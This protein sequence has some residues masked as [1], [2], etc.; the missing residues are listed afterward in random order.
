M[1]RELGK[2][3]N[4][5]LGDF[6]IFDKKDSVE[7]KYYSKLAIK[8]T[9]IYLFFGLAWIIISDTLV[10]ALVT[11]RFLLMNISII[12][13]WLYV[14]I[15]GALI[16]FLVSSAMKKI[17]KTVFALHNEVA[18]QKKREAEILFLSY[19]DLLTGLHNRRYFEEEIKK[20][21]NERNLPVTAILWDVNG[22]KIVND[23]FGHFAGDELL[24]RFADELS[25]VFKTDSI[26]ARWGGDEFAV[27]LPNISANE[28]GDKCKEV[29][30]SIESHNQKSLPASISWGMATKI[31]CED[32]IVNTL[33]HAEDMLY[34]N[35]L[36]Q[37][38]SSRHNI[39]ESIKK[40][41]YEKDIETEEHAERLKDLSEKLGKLVGI[42]KSEEKEL[43]IYASLH[44]IGKI[45]ISDSIL[46]KKGKLNP[47]E[48]EKMKKHTEVGYR[49]VKSVPEL[50]G[51]AEYILTHHERW[52]GGGYP[53]GISGTDIP[54]LS[55]I[56]SIVDAFDAMTNN[57]PYK[58]A[59]SIEEAIVEIKE[60]AGKQFDP[61]MAMLFIDEVLNKK[62]EAKDDL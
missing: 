3:I 45:A 37:I 19:H 52:D 48:W 40:T 18:E 17:S 15:T 41:L 20:Y 25:S 49:I 4:E 2:Y 62:M 56:V 21:E 42:S 9:G 12:K 31:L 13:G 29:I 54:Q 26:L 5:K 47:D 60:N 55:R 38:D 6:D 16:Y 22:L 44:D 11:D 36:T 27:L 58:K 28:A 53:K 51:V 34:R 35:K 23:V 10:G 14:V 7:T 61:E 30:A 8:I 1:K 50:A 33:K 24:K 43:E 57:R 39:I 59:M 46:N 32:T